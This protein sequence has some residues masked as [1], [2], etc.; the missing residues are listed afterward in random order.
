[1][2]GLLQLH[3]GLVLGE[4]FLLAHLHQLEQALRFVMGALAV[5]LQFLQ[6]SLFL[7]QLLL[8][9]Q[10]RLAAAAALRRSLLERSHR[11]NQTANKSTD[12]P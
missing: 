8:Q 6:L 1:M 2:D 11:F 12:Q 10:R 7:G 4:L 3:D 5:L 9:L